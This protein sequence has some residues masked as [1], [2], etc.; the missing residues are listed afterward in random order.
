MRFGLRPKFFALAMLV[1]FCPALSLLAAE[2]GWQDAIDQL[3]EQKY[4]AI[5]CAEVYKK[6]HGE[7][8]SPQGQLVYGE[9]QAGFNGTIAGLITALSEGEK[10][11]SLESLDKK[12]E[13][14]ASKLLNFCKMSA[15]LLPPGST[16]QRDTLDAI[17]EGLG[18]AGAG[19]EAV[20]KALP[21]GV[22]TLYSDYIKPEKRLIQETIKTNLEAAK[23]PDFGE[24]KSA[25]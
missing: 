21:D 6:Y 25:K 1:W 4:N 10:P 13:Q 19:I 17:V 8:K 11:E 7:K 15:D 23:W 18:R 24:I 9:A 16:G 14:G 20:L 3:T 2:M 22:R 5:S 12:L